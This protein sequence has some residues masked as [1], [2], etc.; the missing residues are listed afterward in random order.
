[1]RALAVLSVPSFLAIGFIIA[2]QAAWALDLFHDDAKTEPNKLELGPEDG[3]VIVDMWESGNCAAQTERVA[4]LATKIDKFLNYARPRGVKI[5][6]ALSESSRFGYP[7][8]LKSH[9]W[10]RENPS[11]IPAGAK[12]WPTASFQF[13]QNKPIPS[14]LDLG[15]I[16]PKSWNVYCSESR[17]PA[18]FKLNPNIHLN[19]TYDYMFD[20]KFFFDKM[21]QL[22]A[23][24]LFYVGSFLNRC[25][26]Y[27][28][29]FSAMQ[30]IKIGKFEEVGIIVD[31]TTSL[32]RR[33]RIPVALQNVSS[34]QQLVSSPS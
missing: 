19:V 24:R 7:Q 22:G 28:R 1:M 13:L 34:R 27:A 11:K 12:R 6:H 9:Y 16:F 21:I 14:P 5:F 3:I 23:K 33:R 31:L 4:L 20:D 8:L 32:I 25:V 2:I 30:A 26:L 17:G 18:S 15:E 29:R 10:S